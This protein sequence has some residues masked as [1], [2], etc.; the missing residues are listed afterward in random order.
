MKH[1]LLEMLGPLLLSFNRE[2]SRSC[3]MN[4]SVVSS[5]HPEFAFMQLLSCN[6]RSTR[7]CADFSSSGCLVA[8][9]G[10][11]SSVASST[12]VPSRYIIILLVKFAYSD[13]NLQSNYS[14]VLLS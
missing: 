12:T 6:G 4:T 11:E 2:G 8:S 5:V 7:A 9:E 10:D 14:A 1:C 3:H 13:D